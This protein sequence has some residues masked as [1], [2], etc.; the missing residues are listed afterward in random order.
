MTD[1]EEEGE[2]AATT[3]GVEDGDST[4]KRR[5]RNRRLNLNKLS[6]DVAPKSVFDHLLS[7]SVAFYRVGQVDVNIG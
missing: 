2:T 1:E 4:A 3:N 5:L 7:I 6:R